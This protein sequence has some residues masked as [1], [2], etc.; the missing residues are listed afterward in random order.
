MNA[1]LDNQCPLDENITKLILGGLI[2][3]GLFASYIPQV[4]KL[5][6][7]KTSE[8]LSI[9]FLFLGCLGVTST[10]FNVLLLQFNVVQCC[11]HAWSPLLCAENS[12]GL[13]QTAVGLFCFIVIFALFFYFY[14]QDQKV[15]HLRSSV[16]GE[17]RQVLSKGYREDIY[18]GVANLLYILVAAITA[19]VLLVGQLDVQWV[20]GAFGLIALLGSLFQ[21][22]PQIWQTWTTRS[23][24]ALSVPMILIQCPG[25][26]AFAYSLFIQPNTNWTSWASYFAAGVLQVVLLIICVFFTKKSPEDQAAARPLLH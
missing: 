21:F 14:P 18:I 16:T 20:A 17:I 15:T 24:G 1:L 13:V 12:M 5:F 4:Y 8:G 2:S 9:W 22:I 26:F 7:T 19:T 23:V 11:T 6:Q 10:F 3:V 25:A